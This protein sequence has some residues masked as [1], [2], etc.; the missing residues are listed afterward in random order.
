MTLLQM[1]PISH[2][3]LTPSYHLPHSHILTPHTLPPYS[4][5]SG[6]ISVSK[7]VGH[8]CT[9]LGDA[10]SQVSGGRARR[11][12]S[13]GRGEWLV[14]AWSLQC[15]I[16]GCGQVRTSA[17][18]TMVEIYRHVGVKVRIDLSKRNLPPQ[19]LAMLSTKFDEIDGTHGNVS[20][21]QE[22]CQLIFQSLLSTCTLPPP[23]PQSYP[24]SISFSPPLSP[25]HPYLLLPTPISSPPLSPPPHPYL[26]LP[27]P[28]SRMMPV[29]ALRLQTFHLPRPRP[30]TRCSLL[31]AAGPKEPTPCHAPPVSIE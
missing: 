10:N 2:Y 13:R 19:K 27:T 11:V 17:V 29:L 22:V 30:K 4:F 14:V 3:N 5:G 12:W 6:Q 26:L 31:V 7:Y 28:I 1:Y 16:W 24:T 21:D 9:L 8:I 18:D 15:V 23:P 25:P 20:N